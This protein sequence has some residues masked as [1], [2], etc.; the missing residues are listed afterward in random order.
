MIDTIETESWIVLS[1]FPFGFRAAKTQPRCCL[2]WK[3]LPQGRRPFSK[4]EAGQ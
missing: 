2:P 1:F 4:T 3:L